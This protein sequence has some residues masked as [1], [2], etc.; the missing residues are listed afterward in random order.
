QAAGIRVLMITG[1]HPATALAV[2]RQIG[3][4]AVRVLTGEDLDEAR[5]PA[6]ARALVEVDVFAR[7][8][9]EQKLDLVEAL[10][11]R[12][13]IVAVTGDG[14]NDALALKRADV[15]VAMGGRGSDVSRRGV[16]LVLL[17]EQL[18]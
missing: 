1:D 12:G 11:A 15:G 4:P 6:L 17:Q 3:V 5:G 7:V 2:A 14:V 16:D 10:Q 13:E 9:P 18:V 8:R